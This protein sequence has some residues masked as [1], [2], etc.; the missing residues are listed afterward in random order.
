MVASSLT[1]EARPSTTRSREGGTV[2]FA[3][4]EHRGS[5]ARFRPFRDVFE[6]G[7][8]R[9]GN[10]RIPRGVRGSS[11]EYGPTTGERMQPSSR[12]R[13]GSSPGPQVDPRT[14]FAID[15][16]AGLDHSN[17]AMMGAQNDIAQLERE[18]AERP[19]P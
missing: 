11:K 7:N 16:I 12:R 3:E 17:P 6:R 4:R 19:Q 5:A 8:R 13:P 14:V 18:G 9:C 1:R 2:L 10:S 15:V